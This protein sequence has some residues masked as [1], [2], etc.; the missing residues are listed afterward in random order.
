M[1]HTDP[2]NGGPKKTGNVNENIVNGADSGTN[3]YEE[4]VTENTPK[5]EETGKAESSE[6]KNFEYKNEGEF[7]NGAVTETDHSPE[8][9]YL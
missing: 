1:K 2:K 9:E 5:K 3:N 6:I 8:D 4:P 7:D